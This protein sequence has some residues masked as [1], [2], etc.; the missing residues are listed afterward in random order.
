MVR[1][2]FVDLGLTFIYHR[3]NYFGH[4]RTQTDEDFV[5]ITKPQ[6][7]KAKWDDSDYHA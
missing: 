5:I 3:R 4:H 6:E 7:K 2:E 1:N